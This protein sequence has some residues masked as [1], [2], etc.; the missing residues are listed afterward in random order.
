MRTSD[1]VATSRFI[2]PVE[3]LVVP[4]PWSVG[5]VQVQPIQDVED[6][7]RVAE[8]IIPSQLAKEF[9]GVHT[10]ATLDATDVDEA[11][12][13]LAAALGVLRVYQ[14][15]WAG[16]QGFLRPTGFG[17]PGEVSRT[18]VTYASQ[19]GE[20]FGFGWRLLGGSVGFAFPDAAKTDWDCSDAFQ[21]LAGAVGARHLS[22]GQRR[23]LLAADLLSQSILSH[24]P[25][26]KIISV[27]QAL[28]AL[29]L[30]R[31]RGSQAFRLARNIAFFGCG[32]PEET[33][34]GRDRSTCMYLAND[35]ARKADR[36]NLGLWQARADADPQWR[37]S[38]W[39]KTLDLYATRSALVH[40]E[41]RPVD[42]SEGRAAEFRVVR[43]LLIPILEWLRDHPDDPA[44]DL[45][46][47]LAALPAPPDWEAKFTAAVDS[48]LPSG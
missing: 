8:A 48:D 14:H 41:D 17:L 38:E 33:L 2:L 5:V 32:L 34:C 42:L 3:G 4:S 15:S 35:P 43:W 31:S 22:E 45:E 27:V 10:V 36:A 6:Q 19:L 39:E 20:R 40:G 9:D 26:T 1:A 29:L 23:G 7:L 37:C 44:N 11:I 25:A 13:L 12:Q 21:F 28:E 30:P 18:S 16:M 24:R 47:A 46:A